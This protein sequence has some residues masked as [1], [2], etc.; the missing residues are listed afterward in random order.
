MQK[1]TTK[2]AKLCRDGKLQKAKKYYSNNYNISAD[3]KS[4]IPFKGNDTLV[5]IS[6]VGDTVTL[7][8]KVKR[9]WIDSK[10][11]NISTNADCPRTKTDNNENL[12]FEYLGN[13]PELYKVKFLLDNSE[14]YGVYVSYYIN[15]YSTGGYVKYYSNSSYYNETVL[16][17]SKLYNVLKVDVSNLIYTFYNYNYGFLKIQFQGGKTW[18]LKI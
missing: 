10:T 4:K 12:E 6:D 3:D 17:D 13:N 2:F 18:T 11:S 8:G 14:L 7:I 5:Y 16:L 1:T 9:N 15:N